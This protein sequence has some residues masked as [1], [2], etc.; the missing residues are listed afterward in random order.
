M[1]AYD[2]AQWAEFANTVAGGAAA[3][4]GTDA[5]RKCRLAVGCSAA[6]ACIG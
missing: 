2:V 1:T 4:A 5:D 3:L 6:A